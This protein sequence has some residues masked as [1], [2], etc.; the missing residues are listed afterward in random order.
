MTTMTDLYNGYYNGFTTGLGQSNKTFQMLQPAPPVQKD[1]NQSLWSFFNDI[2]PATL[3]QQYTESSGDQFF[4]QYSRLIGALDP[5]T[6]A[7]PETAMGSTVWA[8]WTKYLGTIPTPSVQ[9]LPALFRSWAM[10]HAPQAANAGEAAYA[11]ILLDP[12]AAAQTELTMF[13]SGKQPDWHVGYTAM[14]SLLASADRVEFDVSSTTMDT[15]YNGSWSSSGASAFFGVWSKSSSSSDVSTKFASSTIDVHATFDHVTPF[16]AAPQGNWYNSA[17]MGMAYSNPNKSPW[18]P[19][20]TAT[21]WD[22]VFGSPN[23]E[24]QRFASNI[25]IASGVNITVTSSATF[26][27]SEQ[28]EITSNE[29]AGLWPFYSKTTTNKEVS[30]SATFKNDTLTISTTSQPGV[31]VVLGVNVLSAEAFVG[32]GAAAVSELAGASA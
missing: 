3:N 30:N 12:V 6:H 1:D 11:Q 13:Y 18:D 23:G 24:L 26:T 21:T 20:N 29:H 10:I 31:P 4:Q 19:T 17:A 15:S 16:D 5:A 7:N 9:Q 2:P 8:A 28:A 22:T 32:A 14:Q 25:V 27:A